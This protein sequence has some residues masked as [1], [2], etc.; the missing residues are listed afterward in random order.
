MRTAPPPRP[1]PEAAAAAADSGDAPSAAPSRPTPPPPAPAEEDA[2]DLGSVVGQMPAV[3]YG[4]PAVVLL[5]VLGIV[6]AVLR[7][8][9]GKRRG[10]TV[11]FGI[12][13]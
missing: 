6:F 7:S 12:K 5:A 11:R 1:R 3:R 2:L 13:L 9:R 4:V 8:R 10:A